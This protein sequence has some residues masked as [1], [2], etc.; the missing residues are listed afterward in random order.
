M[1]CFGQRK[2]SARPWQWQEATQHYNGHGIV[3]GC[4]S[5][6]AAVLVAQVAVADA[7]AISLCRD[8]NLPIVVFNLLENG[9]IAKAVAGKTIGTIIQGA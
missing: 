4:S 9:N 3:S 5:R 6:A 2:L 7:T 8:N 1:N